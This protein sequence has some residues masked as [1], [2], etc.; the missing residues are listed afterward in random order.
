MLAF[1]AILLIA[2]ALCYPI[3]RNRKQLSEV[4]EKKWEEA[5]QTIYVR[6]GNYDIPIL[7]SQQA[8]WDKLNEREKFGMLEHLKAEVKGKRLTTTKEGN[9]TKFTGITDKAKDIKHRQD[10]RNNEWQQ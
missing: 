5:D 8:T 4:A 9:I 7:Q 3:Y 1:I 2:I 6:Y 10:K